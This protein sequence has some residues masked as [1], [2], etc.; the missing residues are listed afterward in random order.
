MGARV[1][2]HIR[3][4]VIGYV[5]LFMVMCLGTAY[6]IDKNQ[7]KSKHIAKNAVKSSDIAN[8]EVKR[9]DLAADSVDGTKVAPDSLTGADVQESSF[10]FP[11]QM[12]PST[13][14]PSGAAGGDLT[15]TYP[16]PDLAPGVVGAPELANDAVGNV[17]LADDAVGI[18]ELA[19]DAVG[20][21]E[22]GL[23]VLGAGDIAT[24]AVD[25]EELSG[26]LGDT[27]DAND[28]ASGGVAATELSD[29]L[30]DSLDANDISRNGV[31]SPEIAN[32]SVHFAD[33]DAVTVQMDH[34][35]NLL[36]EIPEDDCSNFVNDAAPGAPIGSMTLVI[37]VTRFKGTD[38]HGWTAEGTITTTADAGRLRICNNTGRD[39][40]PPLL[41]ITYLTIR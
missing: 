30:G 39:R 5:A 38:D 18:A 21:A 7:I 23:D 41:E 20:S 19:N 25:E 40:D 10:E 34:E 12:P 26:D 22:V 8:G 11:S 1:R 33:L 3:G 35:I 36:D 2:D 29:D 17:A 9:A 37:D 27:V 28:I 6:A 4:N 31:G 32:G 15:G 16:N 24:G 14:P 13:E